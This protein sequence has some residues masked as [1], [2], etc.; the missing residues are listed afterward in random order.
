MNFLRAGEKTKGELVTETI[1]AGAAE[2]HT[3]LF[4]IS[5]VAG[6]GDGKKGAV[7]LFKVE[8]PVGGQGTLEGLLFTAVRGI[9]WGTNSFT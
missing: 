2:E 7:L 9:K 1:A 3:S 8:V 4:I 5:V 6:G